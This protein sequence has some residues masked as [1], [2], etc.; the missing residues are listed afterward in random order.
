[1]H[2]PRATIAGSP[3]VR[4]TGFQ[5]PYENRSAF[6]LAAIDPI[7]VL[8]AALLSLSLSARVINCP[9]KYVPSQVRARR[10]LGFSPV[11]RTMANDK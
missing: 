10:T 8:L 5:R 2:V 11:D 7:T 3:S 9:G 1:M 6:R 4:T